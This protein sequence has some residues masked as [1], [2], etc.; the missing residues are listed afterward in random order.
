MKPTDRKVELTDGFLR[1]VKVPK[2]CDI[3]DTKLEGFQVR[4]SPK[5]SKT[6]A[7][8]ARAPSRDSQRVTLGEYPTMRLAEARDLA[9]ETIVKIRQGVDVAA[10]KRA[11]RA[12]KV[13]TPTLEKIVAEYKAVASAKGVGIWTSNNPTSLPDA[14]RRIRRVFGK[15]LDRELSN[16]TEADLEHAMSKYCRTGRTGEGDTANGQVARARSYLISALDWASGRGRFD[17]LGSHRSL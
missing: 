11:A 10:E 17:Q 1:T 7:V 2:R 3:S 8:R 6:F 5:G 15:L 9:R 14:E 16:L 4:I 13:A 12:Q